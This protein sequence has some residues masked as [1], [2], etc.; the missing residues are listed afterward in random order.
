MKYLLLIRTNPANAWTGSA[1]DLR[2]LRDLLLLHDEL[3][4]SGELLGAEGLAEPADGRIIDATG[5]VPV[6]SDGPFAEAKEQLAG[7]FLVDCATE[8]RAI[9]LATRLSASQDQPIELRPVMDRSE[10]RRIVGL[11]S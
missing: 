8:G 10:L 4:Q 3:A 1:D 2:S 9:E 5:T 11:D 7:Y 6:T